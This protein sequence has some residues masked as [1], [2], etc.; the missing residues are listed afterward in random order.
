[1][2]ICCS[3]VALSLICLRGVPA[4]REDGLGV[5]VAGS[6]PRWAAVGCWLVVLLIMAAVAAWSGRNPIGGAVAAAAA[7]AAVAVL[8]YQCVRRLGGVTGD[9]MGAGIEIAL[10]VMIV[11]MII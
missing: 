6:V 1:V 5:S 8:I 11:V 3:R 10:T 9:V 2:A 4:A 7:A